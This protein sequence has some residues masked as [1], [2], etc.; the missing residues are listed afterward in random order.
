MNIYITDKTG[1]KFWNTSVSAAWSIGER[2]NLTRHLNQIKAGNPA[3]AKCAID[4]DSAC[5]VEE[6]D[7]FDTTNYEENISDD[8]LLEALKG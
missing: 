1:K 6:L 3:Y 7:R 4:R 2:R 8:E 5:I